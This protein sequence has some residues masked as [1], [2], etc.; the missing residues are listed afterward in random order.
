MSGYFSPQSVEKIDTAAAT[1]AVNPRYLRAGIINGGIDYDVAASNLAHLLQNEAVRQMLLSAQQE[2]FSRPDSSTPPAR[3]G[4]FMTL[5]AREV[6]GYYRSARVD[7]SAVTSFTEMWKRVRSYI[8]EGSSATEPSRRIRFGLRKVLSK[9]GASLAG[10]E[11]TFHLLGSVRFGDAAEYSDI[12]GDFVVI[13]DEEKYRAKRTKIVTAVND[14]IDS[15]FSPEDEFRPKNQIRDDIK[16]IDLSQ[17]DGLL[18]DIETKATTRAAD[19]AYDSDLFHTY[20]WLLQ[21]ESP[22]EMPAIDWEISRVKKRMKK[23]A[24]AD[25][26]FEFLLCYK[27]F[28]TI[29]KREDN[30]VRQ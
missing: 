9:H 21:G 12:D 30:L 13:A 15:T 18:T 20:D 5:L 10:A 29:Q 16:I 17:Y 23:A 26:F 24:L 2:V 19:Y 7:F 22:L 27:L 14:G 3:F 28:G 4:E 6:A 1:Y 11:M 25:P 8:R